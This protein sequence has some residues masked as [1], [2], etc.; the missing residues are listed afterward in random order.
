MHADAGVT[1]ARA[2]RDEADARIARHLA[3]GFRHVRGA[4]LV[5]ARHKADA[6]GVVD[7]IEDF[8]IALAWD[9]EHHVDAV[10]LQGVDEDSTTGSCL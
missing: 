10:S 9:A 6:R 3:V 8:E 2:P 7:I 1:G 5:P 4:S